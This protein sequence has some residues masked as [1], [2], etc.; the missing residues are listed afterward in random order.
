LARQ[1]QPALA[2][3]GSVEGYSHGSLVSAIIQT[4]HTM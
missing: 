1:R 2:V 4:L 3:L